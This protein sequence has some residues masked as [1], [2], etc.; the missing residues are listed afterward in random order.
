[1]SLYGTLEVKN[2]NYF[3]LKLFGYIQ[4]WQIPDF[5]DGAPTPG[6]VHHPKCFSICTKTAWKWKKLDQEGWV[7]PRYTSLD[8]PLITILKFPV[9]MLKD[10][11]SWK[12]ISSRFTFKMFQINSQLS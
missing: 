5:S 6:V 4:Q 12:T 7:F 8:S 9:N 10:N 11:F 2:V 3:I 1:M